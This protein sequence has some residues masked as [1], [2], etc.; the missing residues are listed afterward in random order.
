MTNF[1]RFV[2]P[3]ALVRLALVPWS[4]YVGAKI[5]SL[6]T[7][8]KWTAIA[9]RCLILLCLVLAISASAIILRQRQRKTYGS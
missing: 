2:F 7:G 3:W 1:P 4:S 6:S 9:L 8:R 5:R